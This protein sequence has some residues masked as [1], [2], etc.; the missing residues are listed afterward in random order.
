MILTWRFAPQTTTASNMQLYLSGM[1]E[2]NTDLTLIV[3]LI[4]TDKTDATLI[5]THTTDATRN[6]HHSLVH[7]TWDKMV[8]DGW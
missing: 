7:R 6:V 4:V 2:S 3:T 8:K 1:T 5:V